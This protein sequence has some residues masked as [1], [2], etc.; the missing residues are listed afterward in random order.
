MNKNKLKLIVL[1]YDAIG[2]FE[3]GRVLGR[4]CIRQDWVDGSSNC[5]WLALKPGHVY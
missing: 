1:G 4:L 3:C 2:C 5:N